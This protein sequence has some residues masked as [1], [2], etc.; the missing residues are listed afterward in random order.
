[1][2]D[3]SEHILNLSKTRAFIIL[4]NGFT[5]DFLNNYKKIIDEKITDK[6]D[7]CNL[8]KLGDSI[9]TSWSRRPGFLSYKTCQNLWT[10]GAR[11]GNTIEESN[12]LIE[13]IITCANMFF[14]FTTVKGMASKRQMMIESSKD[15]IYLKAYIELIVYLHH[16]FSCYNSSI[17]DDQLKEFIQKDKDWGWLSFFKNEPQWNY[18]K[19]TIVTYNYDIWLER[20]LTILGVPFFISGFEKEQSNSIEI[21]KPH[22]S[23]SFVQSQPINAV[24][25]NYK[26]DNEGLDI[27]KLRVEKGDFG[28]NYKSEIIPPSGDAFRLKST[29]PWTHDLNQN[30]ICQAQKMF[31]G[32][33]VVLCGISY[34]H[35]DRREIDELLLNLDQDV[36]FTFINP[37][38]PRD[39]N[40]VLMSIFKN[41]VHQSSSYHIGGILNGK[42]I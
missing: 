42:T 30:A 27:K 3:N 10:L 19:I 34:W 14:D 22:G 32:D 33:H 24:E 41:Y 6:I 28:N 17:T 13:E 9:R 25:I 23:I 4:G 21:I 35:V 36:E 39:L 1:M 26:L 2:G 7:V 20:I 15:K 12:G 18:S 38:P 40:A 5:I 37:E 16:L 29:A 11:P 8:F 31:K